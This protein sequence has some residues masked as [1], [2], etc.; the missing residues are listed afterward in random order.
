MGSLNNKSLFLFLFFL[1]FP[2]RKGSQL[3]MN[4][5]PDF[6]KSKPELQ[7]HFSAKNKQ[8]NKQTKK[9]MLLSVQDKV[10]GCFVN[11]SG[12]EKRVSDPDLA[13]FP[14]T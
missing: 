8:T 1:P 2:G 7:Q 5:S 14:R 9:N 12:Y 10:L 3:Q 11:G 13:A 6:E 4:Y